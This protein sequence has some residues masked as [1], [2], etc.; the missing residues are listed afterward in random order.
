MVF[1]VAFRVRKVSGKFEKRA[2]DLNDCVHLLG[3]PKENNP[4]PHL[5]RKEQLLKWREERK[6]K[7]LNAES[8]KKSFVVRHVKHDQDTSLFAVKTTVRAK[9]DAKCSKLNDANNLAKKVTRVSARLAK[10]SNN[11]TSKP[12][13]HAVKH[14]VTKA[15]DIDKKNEKVSTKK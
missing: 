11:T 2:L 4:Q 8:E 5:S 12:L 13:G 7:K 6:T 1:E 3:G 15:K 14:S 10:Q 9:G